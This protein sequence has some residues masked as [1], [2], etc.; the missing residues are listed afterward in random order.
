[1]N[2]VPLTYPIFIISFPMLG[3][4]VKG[5]LCMA[6]FMADTMGNPKFCQEKQKKREGKSEKSNGSLNSG[7]IT[8]C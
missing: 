1:M 7:L 3:L 2:V 6:S 5:Y 4:I 8:F